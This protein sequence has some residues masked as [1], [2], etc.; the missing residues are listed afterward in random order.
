[1]PDPSG[2]PPGGDDF[3]ALYRGCYQAIFAYVARR[4]EGDTETAADL[5]AEV[6]VVALRKRD[7][8]PPP[9]EDRLWLYG[10]ARR[11]VLDHQKRHKRQARLRSE[12]RAQAALS[13]A[14][15]GP[16]EM[17]RLRV[18]QAIQQL[19]PAH[20][21]VLQLVAWDGLSHAEAGQVL[22][23]TANA[24]AMRLHHAKARLRRILSPPGAP[25]PGPG[26]AQSQI[27]PSGSGSQI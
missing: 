6:F 15:A 3:E 19:R 23:C 10:V 8:I 24:V 18:R 9:P 14:D 25:E 17:S 1:M 27:L 16:G 2:P 5:T 7:A 21:E 13:G 26:L 11:I 4:V 22:G 20:R 12:L